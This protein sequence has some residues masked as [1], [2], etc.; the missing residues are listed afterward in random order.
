[1]SCRA[2]ACLQS[3]E[4]PDAGYATPAAMILSLALALIATAMVARSVMM[5]RLAKSDIA[6]ANAE[7]VL[8]GAQLQAAAVVIRAGSGGPYRWALPTDLGFAEVRAESEAEK[9]SLSAGASLPDSALATL[10]VADSGALKARLA[11]LPAASRTVV[12]VDRLDPAPLWRECA[13]SLVSGLGRSDQPPK[14]AVEP[15][16]GGAQATA[17]PN[18]PDWRVGEAWRFRI[19]TPAGWRDDRIVRFTGDARHPVAVVWRRLSRSDGGQGRCDA[20]LAAVG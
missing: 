20:V 12:E 6:R 8:D 7:Y 9:L 18:P 2:V 5:L 13:A 17:L 10:G 15:S 19:T 1:M 4:R 3:R 16:T 11:A 14:V